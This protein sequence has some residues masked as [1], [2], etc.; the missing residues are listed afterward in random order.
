MNGYVQVYTG[1]GKGKTTAA[2]GLALRAAGAG[3]R[4][5][6]AQFLKR[7]EYSE[8]ISLRRFGDT[9]TVRQYG[10]P[11]FV[12]G[13][14]GEADI[15]A[16]RRGYA[17]ARE[18]LVSG[19]YDV[20]ILDEANVAVRLGL[21]PVGDMLE[22]LDARPP[23]VELALTGRDADPRIIERADLVTEMREVKHYYQQG[24]Q[25]RKGIEA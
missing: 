1:N 23:E 15:A 24:I 14:P 10:R 3:L 19:E 12:T 17:E 22:L 9:V 11:E 21:I 5:F 20:V 6:F 8:I 4:V 13:V 7:G 25:S 18:A 16:A 2:L